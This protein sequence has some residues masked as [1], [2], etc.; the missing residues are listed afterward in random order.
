MTFGTEPLRVRLFGSPRFL[1]EGRELDFAFRKVEALLVY[2]LLEGRAS[3]EALA[4]LFWGD[5]DE[6]L[7]ARNLR[8]A[9]YRLR[10]TLPPG[11]L[12]TGR[13]W[14]ARGDYP[15]DLDLEGLGRLEEDP[16]LRLRCVRPVLEGFSLPD[17]P[18]FDEWLREVR[19]LWEVR[20]R[21][22]LLGLA[23]RRA[24]GDPREALP[25]LRRLLEA[26]GGDEEAARMLMRCLGRLGRAGGVEEAYRVLTRRLEEDLGIPPEEATREAYR[27]ALEMCRS[28]AEGPLPPRDRG[29]Y[30]REAE[31][32]R[33]GRFF[34]GPSDLPRVVCLEGEAGVGKTRLCQACL[35]ALEP[36]TLVLRGGAV[37]GGQRFPLLPWNDLLRGLRRTRG[38]ATSGPPAPDFPEALWSLLG[39][40]FPSLGVRATS[41]QPPD[42]GRLGSVLA[43]LF[44]NL[45]AVRPVALV[46]EDLH[47]FDGTSLDVLESVL[48]HDPGGVRFLVTSRPAPDRRDRRI[49]RGLERGGRIAL[50][51]LTLLPFD[52]AQTRS[53]CAFLRPDRRFAPEEQEALFRRT[54]GLPLFLVEL[55]RADRVSREE[56]GLEDL[57]EG[58]LT[59]LD[60]GDRRF[61]EALSVFEGPAAGDLLREVAQ[62]PGED[63]EERAERLRGRSLLVEVPEG[64]EIRVDFSH[65][66]VREHLYRSLPEPRRRLLH[67]RLAEALRGRLRG[68]P[69]DGL[70]EERL[71]HHCRRGGLKMEELTQ[72]VESLRRH[73]SL[74]YELFPLRSDEDL[75]RSTTFFGGRDATLERLEA[76]RLLLGDLKRSSVPQ[77]ELEAQE[78]AYRALR[79]GFHL[80]W[81]EYD[82]GRVLVE[83]ALERAEEAGDLRTQGDCLKHRG[84]DAIQREDGPDLAETARRLLALSGGS[85]G[86][87]L[88][89]LALR[90]LGLAHLFLRDVEGAQRA[91]IL[92]M[93]R[94]RALED[95][96]EPYRFHVLA[97]RGYLAEGLARQGRLEEARDLV[98]V[99]L[100]ECRREGFFR[101]LRFFHGLGA[102]GAF[103]RGDRE[104][105]SR[106][107]AGALAE[108]EGLP[109]SRGDA[110]TDALAA[111]DAADRGDPEA[112][113]VHLLRASGLC[114]ALG[115]RSWIALLELVKGLLPRR[116]PLEPLL[117]E[118]PE[119]CLDRAE[120]LFRDLGMEHR[121]RRLDA[122]KGR[123]IP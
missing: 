64:R 54:E 33:V 82:Q 52:L 120:T 63:P 101:G 106:H 11:V 123:R 92:S 70:E 88:R 100:E 9:L 3:R 32:R 117:P 66:L 28:R 27:A 90:F 72:S 71:I 114:G 55:L 34:E 42:P 35:G 56:E 21:A 83:A 58:F 2:V 108:L 45:A 22:S 69:G 6:S 76:T 73:I 86:L 121:L 62:S 31:L 44:G 119:V 36:G 94:F 81:G 13:I 20:G 25:L 75:R 99:C 65:S 57:I 107:L 110:P 105:L 77:R 95:L 10:Q 4:S 93:D 78:R 17:C 18:G 46:L 109:S 47:G 118:P 111:W 43:A 39:Q 91:L 122:L 84:Y 59:E 104:A 115:K 8:N 14:V 19:A 68:L 53:F 79:G 67:R 80:W 23:A 102:Q 7:A 5:R 85:R 61:L 30:G 41:F 113:S 40:A 1:L 49:L 116:G 89:G 38:G 87:P 15:V 112:A 16:D 103:D 26:E 12:E 98:E 48:L 96:G 51:D 50:L 37:L 29:F 60:E 74:Y 97:A 24:E